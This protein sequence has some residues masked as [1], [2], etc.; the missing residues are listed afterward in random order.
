MRIIMIW[1]GL[2]LFI[3]GCAGPAISASQPPLPPITPE[4]AYDFTLETLN[5]E[6][7]NL[8]ELRGQWVLLNFW[9]TWCAPCVKEMPYLQQIA[10]EGQMVVLGINFNESAADVAQFIDQHQIT[11]PI[12]LNP[13]DVILTVYQARSLPR[14]FVIAPDGTVVQQIIGEVNPEQFDAW[15]DQNV[16]ELARN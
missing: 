3:S 5:G 4:P 14:T 7:I 11:F 6:T 13:N 10:D 1:L 12:L 16:V 2:W 15:R 9:A 8:K